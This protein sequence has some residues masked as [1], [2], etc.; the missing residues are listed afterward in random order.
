MF[1]KAPQDTLAYVIM[2]LSF[3]LVVLFSTNVL[4]IVISSAVVGIIAS[5]IAKK[6]G[7]TLL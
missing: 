1:K 7:K 3:A 6:R 5:Y 2:A 4:I